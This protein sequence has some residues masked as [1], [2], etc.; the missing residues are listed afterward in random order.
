M[1]TVVSR[2]LLAIC[3]VCAVAGGA[4]LVAQVVVYFGADQYM[5][6][7]QVGGYGFLI[8]VV[9]LG[10]Y[11]GGAVRLHVVARIAVGVLVALM[12]YIATFV[13]AF[14]VSLAAHPGGPR[15]NLEDGTIGA[16]W[17][18]VGGFLAVRAAMRGWPVRRTA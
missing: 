18:L 17:V 3:A 16:I 7:F 8:G 11:V 4:A 10:L 15:G 5:P 14:L 12:S 13:I 9:G 1:G 6:E 2:V